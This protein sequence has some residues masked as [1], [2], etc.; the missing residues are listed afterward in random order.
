MGVLREFFRGGEYGQV[1]YRVPLSNPAVRDRVALM[2]ARLG[3]G[4]L[5]VDGKCRE[6]IKD[7]EQVSY[8]EGSQ[9][10]DKEKDARRTHLSDALGYLVWQE[11]G[12]C[13][14][15]GERGER[16]PF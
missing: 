7:L 9:V 3:A 8:K 4:A 15:V 12:S 5:T 14:T 11:F 13:G 1:A 16:L 10:I 6:L 2:N